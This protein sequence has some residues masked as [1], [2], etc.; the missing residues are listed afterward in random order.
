M[1]F[2]HA[3]GAGDFK[4]AFILP[5][6]EGPGF[7]RMVRDVSQGVSSN[8]DL[9]VDFQYTAPDRFAT[10]Q[11][12]VNLINAKQ[13]PDYIIFRPFKG[14]AVKVF[15]LLE[16]AQIKFVT[17]ENA[18]DRSESRQ[19][20][21]PGDN[22]R[23]WVN[24]VIYDNRKAGE[25]LLNALI[26]DYKEKYPGESI[27]VVGIGGDFDLVSKDRQAALDH[28]LYSRQT[29]IKVNQVFPTQW[30]TERAREQLPGIFSRYPQTKIFWC[31]GDALAFEVIR[32]NKETI[33][34]NIVVGGFDWLPEAINK[35]EQGSMSA[36][37]GGH[38]LLGAHALLS[39]VDHA[40][41]VDLS[42]NHQHKYAYE[43]ITRGNVN[44]FKSFYDKAL[45]ETANYKLYLK[46]GNA[47]GLTLS[48]KNIVQHATTTHS[49]AK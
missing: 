47:K 39:I 8:L 6:Q 5:D 41:G 27:E 1:L 44:Q 34:T 36:S 11:A 7:W 28:Y 40:N 19:L 30:S 49:T 45:W 13:P 12:I 4:V 10:E 29:S 22:Y 14:N 33:N 38:F 21:L 35:I 2:S 3:A 37:V 43:L 25:L 46:S 24:Q 31:A 17:I 23:Y 32:F 18:F 20:G 15:D 48:V 9:Q 16:R 26:S 42:D